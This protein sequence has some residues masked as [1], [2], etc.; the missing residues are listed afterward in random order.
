MGLFWVLGTVWADESYW[1]D[2][3]TQQET[4]TNSLNGFILGTDPAT[5]NYVYLWGSEECP[6]SWYGVECTS[7][8]T[9]VKLN[10]AENTIYGTISSDFCANIYSSIDLNNNE[11]FSEIP[12]CLGDMHHLQSLRLNNNSLQGLLPDSLGNLGKLE[13]LDIRKNEIAGPYPSYIQCPNQYFSDKTELKFSDNQ[14]WC[15]S[16]K[17]CGPSGNGQCKYCEDEPSSR[18]TNQNKE[19]CDT[20]LI[21]CYKSSWNEA[22]CGD[23]VDKK[24][25]TCTPDLPTITCDDYRPPSGGK[26]DSSSFNWG[27]LWWVAFSVGVV[28]VILAI[29]LFAIFLI[30]LH[31]RQWSFK[32]V[33]NEL[34]KV[35][36]E[37]YV[38][39]PDDDIYQDE[40]PPRSSLDYEL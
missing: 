28:L 35:D 29:G 13:Y 7:S 30:T 39:D 34:I 36:S 2:N 37:T 9:T 14:F 21:C 23:I 11:L 3:S 31:K 8:N 27:A 18:C 24:N 16:P 12:S 38:M 5:W 15:P 20:L 10:L 33:R 19:A 4:L 40:M 17:W 1:C 6:C 26:D 22:T 32:A 25:T